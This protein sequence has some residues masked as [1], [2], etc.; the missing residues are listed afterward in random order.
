L[1]AMCL[2]FFSQPPVNKPAALFVYGVAPEEG[3][4]PLPHPAGI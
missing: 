3:S 4:V 1:N 2:A